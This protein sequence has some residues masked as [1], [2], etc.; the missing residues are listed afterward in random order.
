VL[1]VLSLGLLVTA[2]A[3][4]EK[5][6]VKFAPF[7]ERQHRPGDGNEV[8][9]AKMSITAD[10]KTRTQTRRRASR[11][12]KQETL[13]GEQP[14]PRRSS[15]D[16]PESD[17][18]KDGKKIA[19]SFVDKDVAIEYSG[20]KYTF[21]VDGKPATEEEIGLTDE[22]RAIRRTWPGWKLPCCRASRS[23]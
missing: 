8:E 11:G 3:A 6:T 10:G 9:K 5:Y 14:S 12:P 13:E 21:T 7:C 16:V 4:Q 18:T 22:F 20:E 17:F 23:Q 19:A 1:T 2:A 15:A